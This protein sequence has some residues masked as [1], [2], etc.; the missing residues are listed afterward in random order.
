MLENLKGNLIGFVII[1]FFSFY[2]SSQIALEFYC[3]CINVPGN[4][5]DCLLSLRQKFLCQLVYTFFIEQ[6]VPLCGY[7]PGL[8]TQL[9]RTDT[10]E[11]MKH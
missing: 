4:L 10:G 2:P 11:V 6:E 1:V 7:I 9:F 3:F 8:L 5:Y